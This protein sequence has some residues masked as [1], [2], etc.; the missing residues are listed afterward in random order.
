MTSLNPKRDCGFSLLRD[1]IR[2]LSLVKEDCFKQST[3][4]GSRSLP[5]PPKS[6]LG[7]TSRG[8]FTER[9]VSR[10]RSLPRPSQST[11]HRLIQ[12][13]SPNLSVTPSLQP[14]RVANG[15][16]GGHSHPWTT[17]VDSASVKAKRTTSKS[18]LPPHA[19]SQD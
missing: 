18:G 17:E 2:S 3:V 1:R 9:L 5:P 7:W 14:L 8:Q 4:E 16:K 19:S 12:A 10:V 13:I 15:A 6:R 11:R